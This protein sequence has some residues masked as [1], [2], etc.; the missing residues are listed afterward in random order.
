MNAQ[1]VSL[2]GTRPGGRGS[3]RAGLAIKSVRQEPRPPDAVVSDETICLVVQGVRM[4]LALHVF[5]NLLAAGQAPGLA[6]QPLELFRTGIVAER[7]RHTVD[8]PEELIRRNPG[9]ERAAGEPF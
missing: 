7:L 8:D 5:H 6:D 1:S 4:M 2:C 3:R 9:G